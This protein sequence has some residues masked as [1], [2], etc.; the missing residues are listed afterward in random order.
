MIEMFILGYLLGTAI[1]GMII[2]WYV[3][4]KEEAND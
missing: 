3:G 4:S 1:T 2:T